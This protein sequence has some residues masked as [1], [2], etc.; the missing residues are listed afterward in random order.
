MKYFEIR[1][2]DKQFKSLTSL[3]VEEFDFLKS[4]FSSKW[5]NFYRIHDLKGKKRKAPILNPEKDTPTLPSVEEKLFFILVYFKNYSLQEMLGASYGFSQAQASRWIKILR[6]IL[7][8]SLKSLQLLPQR[9]GS[10]VAQVLIRLKASQCFQD[11]TERLINRAED[12]TTQ[13]EFYSGKKK[14]TR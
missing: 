7:Q 9:K 3:T 2:R 8:D 1:Q 6:P 14:P 4:S 13:K 10:Q 11:A 5:R 12:D